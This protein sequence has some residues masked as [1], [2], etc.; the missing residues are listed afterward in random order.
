MPYASIKPDMKALFHHLKLFIG[1]T[2]AITIAGTLAVYIVWSILPSK[3]WMA[4]SSLIGFI[5]SFFFGVPVHTI[6]LWSFIWPAV[7][8]FAVAIFINVR[9]IQ[10]KNI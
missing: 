6:V 7:I 1:S 4:A 10:N 8:W 5:A 2:I 9:A 3:L